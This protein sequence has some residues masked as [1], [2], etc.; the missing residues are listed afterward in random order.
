ME[1]LPFAS[2]ESDLF[3]LQERLRRNR[4]KMDSPEKV[5]SQVDGQT[6]TVIDFLFENGDAL[7]EFALHQLIYF[8]PT[9]LFK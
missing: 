8:Y 4:L 6:Q 9:S 2:L 1:I 3:I 7:S 5:L